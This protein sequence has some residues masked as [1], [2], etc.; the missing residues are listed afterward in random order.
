MAKNKKKKERSVNLI[1]FFKGRVSTI[2]GLV[3]V[4][5]FLAASVGIPLSY[6]FDH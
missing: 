3:F 6:Y 2:I 5:L 1:M 4:I